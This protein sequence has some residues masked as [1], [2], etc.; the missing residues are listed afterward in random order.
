MEYV[1][2]GHYC[3]ITSSKRIFAHQYVD[4]G[5]PFYRSKEIIEKTNDRSI[6]EPLYI[7]NDVFNL[8]REKFGVPHAGDI[9]LTSVGTLG[10][11]YIVKEETFYFK[12]GNLTWLKDFSADLL[13]KYLYYWLS[14]SFGK[15]SLI[16]LAIGSSQPA[17]TIEILKKYK[18]V[19]PS[20][21]IQRRIASILS[22][23]DNLIELNTRRIKLLEQMAENLYKEW[24]VRFRFPNYQNT[25]IENGIPKGW[26]VEKLNT[27]G[28]IETG[29]T[30]SMEISENYGGDILFVK[31]PDMHK[32][33]FVFNT[34]EKLTEKGHSSQPKKLIPQNSIM[35]SCIGT[36]GVVAINAKPAHT[37]QQ[38]NSIIPTN[39]SD[40]EWLYFA[41]RG[42]KET[43]QL[44][45]ATGATMTNLSKGKFE[46]LKLITPPIDLRVAYH[47]T[48]QPLFSVIATLQTKSANLTRQ[49]DLLLPRLMSGQLPTQ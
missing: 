38:I 40:L 34:E 8:I 10:I 45:G 6:S 19:L 17:L 14:S 7:S 35:V 29:K 21:P 2:L 25:P 15:Q 4:S 46:K 31:T 36:A 20:L 30:P 32:Q 42:L 44:F 26:K 11:P 5:I 1:R 18:I 3:T 43:I 24:F 28:K 12:D 48:I 27:F 23:Y 9:L 22:S 49:R 39:K 13:P 16:Q 37:N 41:C 47:N 33:L